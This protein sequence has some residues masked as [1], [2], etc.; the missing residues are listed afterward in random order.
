MARS[1]VARINDFNRSNLGYAIGYQHAANLIIDS[2]DNYSGH[3]DLLFFP[4]AFLYRH[5][6]ELVL[7]DIIYLGIALSGAAHEVVTDHKLGPL[8]QRAREYLLEHPDGSDGNYFDSIDS[9]IERLH[10]IDPRSETFRYVI[11][12]DRNITFPHNERIDLDRLKSDMDDLINK[13]TGC[14]D[15]LDAIKS[16]IP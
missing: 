6:T 9:S 14:V 8:W 7:K 12:K 15:Y 1:R 4:L 11:D 13:L 10:S 5:A 2:L 3:P 16:S